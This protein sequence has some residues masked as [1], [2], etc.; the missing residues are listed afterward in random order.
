[1]QGEKWD[2]LGKDLGGYTDQ[3]RSPVKERLGA[4]GNGEHRQETHRLDEVFGG[5][6]ENVTQEETE[7]ENRGEGAETGWQ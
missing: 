4:S 5:E 1:M 7:K 6:K 2:W 3:M